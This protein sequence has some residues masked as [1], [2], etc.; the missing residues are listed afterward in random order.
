M[1][2]TTDTCGSR[3]SSKGTSCAVA[4]DVVLI[5]VDGQNEAMGS[6]Q[7]LNKAM[8]SYPNARVLAPKDLR[9]PPPLCSMVYPDDDNDDDGGIS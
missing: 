9:Y 2:M 8:S 3:A 6:F 4:I 5:A 1:I 7:F